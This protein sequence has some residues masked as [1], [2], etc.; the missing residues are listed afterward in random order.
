MKEFY[1]LCLQN[2]GKKVAKLA[3]EIGW[4]ETNHSINT[5][6]L[7]ADNWGELK[8]KIKKNNAKSDVLVFKGGNAEL[9]RKA[10]ENSFVDI[11]L[12]PEKD[13]KDSGL[14]HIIAEKAA[15][16]NVAIG[17]DLRQ[18]NKESKDQT[19]ILKHWMKNLELCEKYGTSYIITSGAENRNQLRAPR[20]IKSIID[21][22]GFNGDKAVKDNPKSIIEDSMENDS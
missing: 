16:N 7:E 17:F 19:H 13:R 2:T 8:T 1:D 15:E 12:H 9:N 20:D 18:L 5:V 10:A 6:F 22:L 11:I 4:T 14:D 3:S 21:V